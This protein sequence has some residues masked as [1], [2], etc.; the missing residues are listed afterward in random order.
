MNSVLLP[1]FLHLE[2]SVIIYQRG[3]QD[4]TTHHNPSSPPLPNLLPGGGAVADHVHDADDDDHCDDNDDDDD[5]AGADADE[6]DDGSCSAVH[7]IVFRSIGCEMRLS[8][9]K[10]MLLSPQLIAANVRL[11]RMCR[12]KDLVSPRQPA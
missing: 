1:V 2:A 9:Y 7:K 3:E 12:L 4:S 5:A 11:Q 10:I 8:T 6:D